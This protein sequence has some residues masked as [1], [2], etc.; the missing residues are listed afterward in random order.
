MERQALSREQT[1][2]AWG[3]IAGVLAIRGSLLLRVALANLRP[4]SALESGWRG[5]HAAALKG[6]ASA[7][8]LFRPSRQW[9]LLSVFFRLV[10]RGLGLSGF[11][12]SFGRFL[13]AYEPHNPRHFEA[14][15]HLYFGALKPRDA[16]GLLDSLEEPALGDGDALL[17]DGKRLSL[18]WLQSVDEFYRIQNAL[19]FAR[20]DR[21]TFCELGPGYGRLAH[22][23][24]S[25]MPNARVLLFDL[26]ES[27][28]LSEY[29]LTSLHPKSSALLYPESAGALCAT[30]P[31]PETRLIFGL[32]HQ[33][34]DVPP[35]TIDVFSNCYSFME[36]S[37]EQI[38]AYFQI[39]EDLKVGALFLKQHK[40]EVNFF[41]KAVNDAGR[42]PVRPSWTR[43]YEGTSALYAHVFEA[44]YRVSPRARA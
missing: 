26:P 1:R 4:F 36:M 23:I 6:L 30:R 10:L 38:A 19:G 24:L 29:Y 27:L 13:A 17:V 31:L 22:V 39:I 41:D 3:R 25:A 14:L 43:L 2:A 20:Q 21:V 16:W 8:P 44:V 42:Y 18:D 7:D 34:K 28:V 40:D 15:H 32:P 12:R 11:K 37:R 33:L 35:G 5:R 9:G